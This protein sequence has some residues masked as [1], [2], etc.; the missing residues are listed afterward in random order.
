MAVAYYSGN[1]PSALALNYTANVPVTGGSG[2][3]GRI[4]SVK[5]G[6]FLSTN[7][8]TNTYS[9]RCTINYTG[10]S[11]SSERYNIKFDSG[12]YTGSEWEFVFGTDFNAAAITSVDFFGLSD[13]SKIFVKGT[14]TIQVDYTL[15]T[16]P[17]P[18]SSVYLSN[19]SA[20]RNEARNL[21]FTG[22]ADGT[23]NSITGYKLSRSDNGAAW[24]DAFADA[25]NGMIVYAHPEYGKYYK[26]R[27]I[28][29]APYGNSVPSTA[30]A[31][32]TVPT[33][34]VCGAPTS[35][36]LDGSVFETNPTLTFSGASGGTINEITAYEIEYAEST[37]NS[38]WGAWTALEVYA[39]TATSGT[40]AVEISSTRGNYR[41]Y[42]IRTRGTE[43]ATYYSAWKE[44]AS[45]RRNSAPTAPTEF[46]ATPVV[47]VSGSITLSYSGA[48]DADSN[49]SHHQVDYAISTNG[50]SSY[51]GW[52]ALANNAVS[53]APTLAPSALIKYRARAVDAFGIAS[54]YK[55]SNACGKNTAPSKPTIN[56]P[57]ASKTTH[58]SKPRFLVTLGTDP[59]SHMQTIV[60]DG[61]AASRATNLASGDK[62]VLRRTTTASAGSVSISVNASDVHG[63]PAG[64]VTRSTT[65]SAPSYTDAVISKGGTKIKAA[66]IN[67]LR[68][69]VNNV[70]VYYGLAAI[71]WAESIVAGVTKSRGWRGHIAEIR[72]AI[73]D[74][75]TLVN[76]WDT[77]S[78]INRITAPQWII[79][80]EKPSAAAMEQLRNLIEQL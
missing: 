51:G 36:S 75:V 58:N 14:Q 37:N 32:L 11:I 40:R 16:N 80:T 23:A 72:S 59:E 15:R 76:G 45:V 60:A 18:P 43:G 1:V 26:Y 65:Y 42:R 56:Y 27:I 17:A 64:A 33:P 9:V 46:S 50:G 73:N 34:T 39:R 69:M 55:E 54:S 49:I 8:Y 24:D 77:A 2:I 7:A 6:A 13:A 41:K 68:V 30:T 21:Y 71:S 28:C 10:G 66:H 22:Q 79:V 44:T 57:A 62:V 52:T 61:Y 35:A 3:G 5:L 67:E 19:A 31:T 38:A 25:A 78:A 47:F 29:L 53:H 48:T 70:R 20:K 4:N 74:V 63:E 12:N